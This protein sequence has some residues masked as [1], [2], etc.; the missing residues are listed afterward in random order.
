[1]APDTLLKQSSPGDL[2]TNRISHAPL[3]PTNLALISS[4]HRDIAVRHIFPTVDIYFGEDQENLN[5]GLTIFDRAKSD[6]MFACRV[7]SLRLHWAHE[8]GDMLCQSKRNLQTC[9]WI[10]RSAWRPF[11]S[12]VSPAMTLISLSCIFVSRDSSQ[13]TSELRAFGDGR[14]IAEWD[15]TVF[16]RSIELCS[17]SR[18]SWVVH[19]E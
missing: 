9:A 16:E 18:S 11:L 1:M 8:E 12:P 13:K 3:S 5:R 15:A 4:F 2:G 7:K 17:A 10:S 19:T 14:W 6:P